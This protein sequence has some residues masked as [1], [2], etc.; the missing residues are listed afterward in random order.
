MGVGWGTGRT[1]LYLHSWEQI[2]VSTSLNFETARNLS[3]AKTHQKLG[4][5]RII[6]K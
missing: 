5:L 1:P 6:F 4:K 2:L 3:G